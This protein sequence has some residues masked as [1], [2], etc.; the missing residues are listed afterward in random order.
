ME[1][2]EIL[3][4]LNINRV[5]TSGGKNN[6]LDG[7]ELISKLVEASDDKIIIMPGSG[8]NENTIGDILQRTQATEFH[9]S[10]KTFINSDMNYFN[11]D[12]KLG[13]TNNI[14]EYK[15]ISVNIEQI[16]KMKRA[17]L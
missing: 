11:P 16:K 1:S 17:L 13:K 7:I 4:N 8:V 6:A 2:L 10:A 12:I 14:D 9:S 3:K 15:K 5:L